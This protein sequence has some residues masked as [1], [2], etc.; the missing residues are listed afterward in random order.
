VLNP[1]RERPMALSALPF[2]ASGVLVGADNR[3][4]N[5]MQRSQRLFRQCPEYPQPH[6]F[7]GPSVEAVIDRRVGPY[8][9]GRAR[10]GEP[11]RKMEKMPLR[12][13]RSS[14]R[15]TPRGLFGNT[16]AMIPNSTF[17]KSNRAIVQASV[18]WKLESQVTLSRKPPLWVQKLAGPW[19]KAGAVGGQS[20]RHWLKAARRPGGAAPAAIPWARWR[21]IGRSDAQHQ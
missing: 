21:L 8:R 20:F 12:T 1:P 15:G 14:W 2:A 19:A 7:L 13:R 5:Q 11:V 16:G 9:S 3:A 17:A 10:H 18:V 6:A 4:V